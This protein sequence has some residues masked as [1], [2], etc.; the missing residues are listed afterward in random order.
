[1]NNAQLYHV[2][3]D[4]ANSGDWCSEYYPGVSPSGDQMILVALESMMYAYRFDQEGRYLERLEKPQVGYTYPSE[5]RKTIQEQQ[6]ETRHRETKRREAISAWASELSLQ[7][8]TVKVLKFNSRID[9]VT[10]S[11]QRGPALAIYDYPLYFDS[12]YLGDEEE[13]A[14]TLQQWH[15]RGAFVLIWNDHEYAIDRHG[16]LFC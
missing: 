6:A 12:G 7:L 5:I 8:A 9:G 10:G 11:G 1:M 16:K 14:K 3:P 4:A 13:A 15:D 2:A